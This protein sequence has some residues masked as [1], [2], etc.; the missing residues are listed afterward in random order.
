M[1][2]GPSNAP[3]SSAIEMNQLELPQHTNSLGTVFGGT[4]MSWIDVCA[5]M[6]AQRHARAVVVTASMDQLDFVAPIVVGQLV[7]LRALVNYVGRTS[8]EVGVRVEAE[9][10]RTGQRAHAAS[11]YLTFVALDE[12]TGEPCAVRPLQPHSATEKL[13]WQ[14]AKARREQRLRLAQ[15]RRRLASEHEQRGDL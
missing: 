6:A 8:M 15:E 4:I 12:Q 5:A 9:N 2:S 7:N 10:T 1:T 3:S 13:R 11:A 14:E